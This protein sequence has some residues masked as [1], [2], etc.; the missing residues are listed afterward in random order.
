MTRQ[1]FPSFE[2]LIP[3]LRKMGF[4][5]IAITD[6][7]IAK[8]PGYKPFDTGLAA[9]YFVKNADGTLYVGKVWP[10]DS[11]FPEFTLSSVRRSWGTLYKNFFH[12]GILR[13]CN[14][15]TK[16]PI[17]YPPQTLPPS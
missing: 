3:D 4:S 2:A 14:A 15:M 11:V 12:I 17:F 10:G 7:H 16:P 1:Y 13:F 8:V 5:V 9:D 6:L